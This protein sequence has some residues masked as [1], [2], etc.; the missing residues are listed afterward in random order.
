VC[1]A[2]GLVSFAL[3]LLFSTVP[4]LFTQIGLAAF[5]GA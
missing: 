5:A 3:F 1:C 2:S 4:V